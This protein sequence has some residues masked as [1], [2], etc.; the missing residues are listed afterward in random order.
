MPHHLWKDWRPRPTPTK[1]PSCWR[2]VRFFIFTLRRMAKQAD[3]SLE[4]SYLVLLK[5]EKKQYCLQQ[6][7]RQHSSCSPKP[8]CFQNFPALCWELLWFIIHTV[9][10]RSMKQPHFKTQGDGVT[11]NRDSSDVPHSLT[12]DGSRTPELQ[13][14]VPQPWSH[15]SL[16]HWGPQRLSDPAVNWFSSLNWLNTNKGE[17]ANQLPG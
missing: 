3:N 15:P 10:T 1:F 13:P 12:S 16:Q 6:M 4:K 7:Q 17:G 11:F 14:G 2:H 8:H 5:S 9:R